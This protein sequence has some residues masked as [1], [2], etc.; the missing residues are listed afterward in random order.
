ML[1]VGG[2]GSLTVAVTGVLVVTLVVE[3]LRHM[4]AGVAVGGTNLHLPQGSQEIGLGIVMA[5]IMIFR[6]S[7]LTR[8][9]EVPWPF[10]PAITRVKAQMARV[11]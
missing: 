4:E 6:P 9:R 11:G 2:V 10:R 7:G 5:L 3:V 8:G 1:V